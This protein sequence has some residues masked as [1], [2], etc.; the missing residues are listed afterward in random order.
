MKSTALLQQIGIALVLT[1]LAAINEVLLSQ[2]F[3]GLLT[4]KLNL[5]FIILLYLS[6]LILR[7][8]L[9]VGRTTLM[10]INLG[11]MLICLITE[12]SLSTLLW[13]Y[14]TMIWINRSL[15]R[16]AGMVAVLAD[17][18]LSLLG[19]GA[20][21]WALSNGHGLITALWCFLLIQAL[22]ILIPGKEALNKAKHAASVSDNFGRA[23]QSAENALQQLLRKV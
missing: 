2:F 18:G 1:C 8:R 12:T 7:N 11:L 9:P 21:L 4:A 6:Y 17:L 14:P 16:Y 19:I 22:H 3:T 13:V 15:L 5:S 10:T 23:L 20:A